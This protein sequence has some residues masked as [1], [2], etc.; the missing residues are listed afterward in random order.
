MRCTD[1]LFANL[2]PSADLAPYLAL[3]ALHTKLKASTFQ[4]LDFDESSWPRFSWP[5]W[6]CSEAYYQF[7]NAHPPHYEDLLIVRLK[8]PSFGLGGILPPSSLS[9]PMPPG[10]R[11][12]IRPLFIASYCTPPCNDNSTVPSSGPRQTKEHY[13]LRG[14]CGTHSPPPPPLLQLLEHGWFEEL[15]IILTD[16]HPHP[17]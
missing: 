3:V 6:F 2:L 4:L 13:L 7:C 9:S 14:L 8:P 1:H 17:Q 5:Q 11:P 10:M 12:T 16:R 15:I